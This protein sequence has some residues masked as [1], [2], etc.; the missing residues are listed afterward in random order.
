MGMGGVQNSL[1]GDISAASYNPAGLGM[2][3]RSELAFT[4][5]YTM[6]ST[7][8]TYLGNTENQNKNTLIIPNFGVAI[9]KAKDGTTGFLGGTFGISYN[10]TNSF[11]NTYSY[12]G[13]N[14][15]NSIID[16]FI[17][18]ANGDTE[19][20]FHSVTGYNFNTPTGL[21][22]NNF[23]IGPETVIDPAGDPRSYFTDVYPYLPTQS[24][25]VKTTGSQGQWNFSYGANFSDK[26]FV[27]LGIGFANF[28]YKTE[29]IYTETFLDAYPGA[30]PLVSPMSKM[31]LNESFNMTGTGINAT[32]GAIYRPVDVFQ[33][34]VSIATPTS[35]QI[36]SEYIGYMNTAWNNFE[37]EPGLILGNEDFETDLVTFQHTLATPWRFSG[38]GTFFIKK[39]GL[40]SV[41]VEYVS[42]GSS[43]Y[44]GYSDGSSADFDNQDIK[45]LYK[46]VLNLRIG[47][48]YRLK[49]FRF[50]SGFGLMPDPYKT[51]QNNVDNTFKTYSFGFGYRVPKFYV[52]IATILNETER[53]YRPYT[54]PS[55]ASPLVTMKNQS[56]TIAL[57]L[58]F[59]F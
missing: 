56:T 17:N 33:L 45:S 1:G 19:A 28:E 13:T 25:V 46:S 59:P 51:A 44:S 55:D 8:A 6:T 20:Q 30:T 58:G 36:N 37:Y 3:N 29:A 47:G 2:Y 49:N 21:A 40:I 52:D 39:S 32:L 54:V 35:Y 4:P 57:T 14:N 22:Y 43:S 26:I 7:A 34:G 23:L 24:E 27:G 42:Y 12:H 48:E 41:D 15:D 16:Y 11:N 50:R 38:G 53:S 31:V 10:R 9:H 18:D 5:G